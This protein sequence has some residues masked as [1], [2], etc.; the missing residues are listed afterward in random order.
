MKFDF[1]G[2]DGTPPYLKGVLSFI[3]MMWLFQSWLETR[4]LKQLQK[5]KPPKEMSN[6]V[7]DKE[8]RATRSYGL[9]KWY[10]GFLQ[11]TVTTAESIAFLAWGG[12]SALWTFSS[13]LSLKLPFSWDQEIQTSVIF[14]VVYALATTLLQQ[15]FSLY[16]TFVL[17]EKH[18]FNKST[19]GVYVSDLLKG[20]ALLLVMAPPVVVAVVKILRSTGPYVAL[21]LWAFL[22]VLNVFLMTIYPTI[23]AP[24]FNKYSP[25]EEGSLK[26]K[27]EGLAEKLDYPLR[28]LFVMDASKRSG[29]SNAYMYGF[30]KNKR[31][32]LFDTLLNQCTEEE[33]VAILAH[34]LGHWK[35]KHTPVLLVSSMTI[36]LLQLSAYTFIS[37]SSGLFED[38]GFHTTKPAFIGLLLF[39]YIISPIDV[40]IEF[41]SNMLSRLF[42]FQADRFAVDQG[43][44]DELKAALMG[45]HKENKSS[46][47]IDPLYSTYHFSHPPLIERIRAIDRASKKHK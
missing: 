14:A 26:R 13:D 42:E 25:L 43:Y 39:Q 32:V 38:F 17:E 12:L 20:S 46:Y 18:G 44:P 22:L 28:K 41:L 4:Q 23:I 15:P 8:F 27:I 5:K 29:H 9:D 6:M 45:L 37:N 11:S 3:V 2:S 19:L 34:E 21:Y 16:G 35:L 40:V 47:N 10:F 30:Y 33:I 7:D 36:L 1:G 31:I 24:M